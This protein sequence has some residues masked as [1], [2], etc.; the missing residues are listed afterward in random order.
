M[1]LEEPLRTLLRSNAIKLDAI[2][3]SEVDGPNLS[4][5]WTKAGGEVIIGNFGDVN[6][7]R[8]YMEIV[9]DWYLIHRSADQLMELA[10]AA[11]AKMENVSIG[12]E[13]EGVNLFLHVR[14]D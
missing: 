3:G 5:G 14:V 10:R 7:S 9:G 6:P 2:T 12:S 1:P 4:I 8:N 11:G 13:L